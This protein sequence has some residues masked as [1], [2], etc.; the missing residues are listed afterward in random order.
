VLVYEFADEGSHYRVTFR[1]ERDIGRTRFIDLLSGL[2]AFFARLSGFEV[3]YLRVTGPATV[4]RFEG[5][6]VVETAVACPLRFPNIV[7]WSFANLAK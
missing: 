2:Q 3:A 7:S 6:Q 4:E 1:R 5:D